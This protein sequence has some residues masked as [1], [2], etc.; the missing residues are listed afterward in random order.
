[1]LLAINVLI[2]LGLTAAPSAADEGIQKKKFGSGSVSYDPTASGWGTITLII[3]NIQVFCLKVLLKQLKMKRKN[4]RWMDIMAC[5][6]VRQLLEE[7]YQL[8]K[9]G[10]NA[11]TIRADDNFQYHLIQK[12]ILKFRDIIKIRKELMVFNEEIIY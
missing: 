6:L 11:S 7:I 5:C 1:M 12:L 2:P 3:L 9:V 8:L 10:A 4:K